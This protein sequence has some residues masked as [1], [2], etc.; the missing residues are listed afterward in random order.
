MCESGNVLIHLGD[1]AGTS[2]TR[3]RQCFQLISL[4][5]VDEEGKIQISIAFKL[6]IIAVFRGYQMYF[7]EYPERYGDEQFRFIT[8]VFS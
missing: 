8:W 2:K 4:F 7:P 3:P 6:G 5:S 1:R